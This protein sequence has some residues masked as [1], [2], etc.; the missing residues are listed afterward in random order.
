MR[1]LAFPAILFLA[2]GFVLTTGDAR[3]EVAIGVVDVQLMLRE[4]DAAYDI[5]KQVQAQ[6][7]QFLAEVSKQEQALKALEQELSE[8]H[9]SMPADEFAEKRKGF[10]TR[11]VETRRLTLKRKKSL[12]DAVNTAMS[13][14]TE[15]IYKIVQ[16]IADERGY[17]MVLSRQNVVVGGESVDVTEDAMKRLN[18]AVSSVPLK[19]ESD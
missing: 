18:K 16:E 7:E 10:E 5:Q 6:K 4:S 14:L 3:A 12:D 9:A 19:I 13:A 2:L 1:T 11:F 15:H 17:N 8:R